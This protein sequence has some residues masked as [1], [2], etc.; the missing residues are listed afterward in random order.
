MQ[1][2]TSTE[3]PKVII[4]RSQLLALSETFIRQQALALQR[5]CPV[6]VGERCLDGG[7]DL[8]GLDVRLLR[9]PHNRPADFHYRLCRF[10]RL[11]HRPTVRKLRKIGARLVHVHFGTDAVDIWPNVRAL[12][13]PMVVTLHGFDINIYREWWEAG[14]GGKRQRNYPRHLLQLAREPA[15][16]FIAVSKAIRARAIEYG[17][18]AEKIVVRYIGVDTKRFHPAG[19]P[20]TQR[21]KRILFI[22]RLVENKGAEILIRAFCVV[23]KTI[24]DAELVIAGNGALRPDLENLALSMN[25]TVTFLGAVPTSE[26]LN[27]LHQARVLCQPS[28]TI[29]NGASEA[30]GIVVLEAQACGV[31]VISSAR[32]GANEGILDGQTGLRFTEGDIAGL[33]NSLIKLLLNNHLSSKLSENAIKFVKLKFD[34]SA[35]T[36]ALEHC[37]DAMA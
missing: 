2:Q 37:Y 17:I 10:A 30:L 15:V 6:L 1:A 24:Q 12:G 29:N 32:G 23:K 18:P 19:Q 7:L 5:W 20:I 36:I 4:Y 3:I 26:V 35:C 33:A 21:T 34:L 13:L 16:R 25:I 28:I 11:P 27:Q 9:N 31:P 14:H 8:D 22:G